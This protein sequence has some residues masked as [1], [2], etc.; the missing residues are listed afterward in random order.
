MTTDR[1][2]LLEIDG[3]RTIDHLA[4]P[5]RGLTVLIGENGSGKSTILEACEL[6]R[7]ASGQQFIRE[8]EG[9]HGGA[10]NLFRHGAHEIRLGARLEGNGPP[11][12]Y[13][14][15]LTRRA[16][17]I[18]LAGERF[19]LEPEAGQ[20]QPLTLI[21]R[22]VDQLKVYTPEG[23]KEATLDRAI[24][25][26]GSIGLY[27]PHPAFLRMKEALERIE[28]HLPF[29]VLPAWAAQ[30]HDRPVGMRTLSTLRPVD[31]LERFGSNLTNAFAA[32]R[33]EFGE[34]HWRTTMDYVR[35]GLGDRIESITARAEGGGTVALWIKVR[36]SDTLIPASALADGMLAYLSFVALA[37]LRADRTLL[38][39][40]EPE[41]HLH[42]AL[43]VRVLSFFESM[44]EDHPVLLATHSDR[45]LDALRE[46]ARAVRV[47]EADE[48]DGTTRVRE[49][50][51]V[52]LTQWLEDYRGLGDLRSAGYL[53]VVTKRPEP[54]E[55]ASLPRSSA[56]S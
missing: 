26:L 10:I 5:L 50:D 8:V 15:R 45:L 36:N 23:L 37:R 3:L 32:L 56:A 16:Q 4:L 24:L 31:R 27:S 6:L 21:E 51:E 54:D 40:D 41:L 25:A 18:S 9:I 11:L 30:A 47:C 48:R 2:T 19:T 33:S 34:D 1:I 20:E 29:D 42:P 43:L 39:F 53:D 28:V 49:L 46:P 12:H 55:P 44:A 17:S 13:E 35:L 52:A 22:S 14:L 38:A 7:R